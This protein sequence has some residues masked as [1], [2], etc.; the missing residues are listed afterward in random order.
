MGNFNEASTW[1][2]PSNWIARWTRV[3][4]SRKVG[5]GGLHP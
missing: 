1:V 4:L 5:K 2:L 3:F